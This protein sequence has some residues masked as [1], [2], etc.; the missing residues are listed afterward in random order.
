M[1]SPALMEVASHCEKA[2]TTALPRCA[3]ECIKRSISVR[4][5]FKKNHFLSLKLNQLDNRL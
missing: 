3:Q 1:R 2:P 4:H 5:L